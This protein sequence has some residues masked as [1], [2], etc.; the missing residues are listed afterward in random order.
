MPLT[1]DVSRVKGHRHEPALAVQAGC[2]VLQPEGQCGAVEKGR[3]ER[4]EGEARAG[5][6]PNKRSCKVA[7][8]SP[9]A[10]ATV[11]FMRTNKPG[12]TAT[13][14]AE[15]CGRSAWK[16]PRAMVV[17]LQILT[18]VPSGQA[19]IQAGSLLTSSNTGQ[20]RVIPYST[21]SSGMKAI[22]AAYE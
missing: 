1:R 4:R 10:R 20:D 15:T 6:G 21:S 22:M 2:S 16:Q 9:S 5:A 19:R 17:G 3:Q 14:V 18:C 13:S 11:T 7:S 8:L 12:L